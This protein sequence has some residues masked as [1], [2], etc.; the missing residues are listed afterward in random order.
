MMDQVFLLLLA[1][2]AFTFCVVI[3][4]FFAWVCGCDLN[5]PE[6]YERKARRK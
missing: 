3:G 5:E 2:F 1:L 4:G 6:Y